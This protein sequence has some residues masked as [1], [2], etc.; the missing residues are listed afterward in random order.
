MATEVYL[1]KTIP[2][3]GDRCLQELQNRREEQLLAAIEGIDKPYP[4]VTKIMK[5]QASGGQYTSIVQQL[6]EERSN[7]RTGS[8]RK[9]PL[10]ILK[11]ICCGCFV[12]L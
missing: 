6:K 2:D 11:D 5:A 4:S 7:P 8:D 12:P 10:K 3:S 9:T 1:I